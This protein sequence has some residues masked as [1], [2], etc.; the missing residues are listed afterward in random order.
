[1]AGAVDTHPGEAVAGA[2][3]DQDIG[4][5]GRLGWAIDGVRGAGGRG[6]GH[7]RGVDQGGREGDHGAVGVVRADPSGEVAGQDGPREGDI[8]YCFSKCVGGDPQ[9]DTAG[10][11]LAV[12]SVLAQLEPPGIADGLGEA[13]GPSRIVEIGHGR[14]TEVSGQLAGSAPEL[15]LLGG[16]SSIHRC[17]DLVLPR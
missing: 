9:F 10:Q 15:S 5:V 16:V 11:R 14:R 7:D 8:S 6:S 17:H 1:V 4:A 2:C 13:L 3:G 12:A